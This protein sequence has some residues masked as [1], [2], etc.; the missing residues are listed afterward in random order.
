MSELHACGPQAAIS[1]FVL[2]MAGRESLS[3]ALWG[4]YISSACPCCGCQAQMPLSHEIICRRATPC[5]LVCPAGG[6]LRRLWGDE[7]L[8]LLLPP[9]LAA[10]RH[11]CQDA[12]IQPG[13]L[14][15]PYTRRHADGLAASVSV[16]RYG[17]APADL[18]RCIA[19]CVISLS[20]GPESGPPFCPAGGKCD[21]SVGGPPIGLFRPASRPS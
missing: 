20:S 8:R 11:Q 7:L 17:V 21:D 5:T 1:R 3:R 18:H 14:Q 19:Q 15:R 2:L 9:V 12:A 4:P 10:P 13:G 6:D 16:E